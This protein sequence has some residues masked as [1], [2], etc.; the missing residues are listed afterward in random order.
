VLPS[1]RSDLTFTGPPYVPK[2]ITHAA[3]PSRLMAR[4]YSAPCRPPLPPPPC[5]DPPP[6]PTHTRTHHT[7]AALTQAKPYQRSDFSHSPTELLKIGHENEMLVKKLTGIS[8][9]PTAWA[10]EVKK[11]VAAASPR[12]AWS[13][14]CAVPTPSRVVD[15]CRGTCRTVHRVHRQGCPQRLPPSASSCRRRQELRP[16][17]RLRAC[18]CGHRLSC[19]N[20]CGPQAPTAPQEG[21]AAGAGGGARISQPAQG[22]RP[23]RQPE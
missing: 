4:N 22:C 15:S 11:W 21:G 23:D 2:V 17:W 16:A 18:H 14:A 1:C 3:K 8:A 9:Q 5:P 19:S 13:L 20:C 6:H 10:K 7:R 12:A